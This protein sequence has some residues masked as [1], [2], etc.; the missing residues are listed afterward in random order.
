M[1]LSRRRELISEHVSLG[2]MSFIKI[3]YKTCFENFTIFQLGSNKSCWRQ[4]QWIYISRARCGNCKVSNKKCW[5]W[6][7]H[8]THSFP[9]TYTHIFFPIYRMHKTNKPFLSVF[10]ML[11]F[12]KYCSFT[13]PLMEMRRSWASHD[14]WW[15]FSMM[16]LDASVF[17]E[18][19]GILIFP[20]GVERP[21]SSRQTSLEIPN[22][23]GQVSEFPLPV[24]VMKSH[25]PNPQFI[26]RENTS[27]PKYIYLQVLKK[28]I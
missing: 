27:M 26:A 11:F 13:L 14:N 25:I 1:A 5:L 17:L 3:K 23:S 7:I 16:L 15:C 12:Y 19:R 28:I 6:I 22:S 18:S 21:Y 20:T 24:Q 9:K 10:L 4:T 2:E 8:I